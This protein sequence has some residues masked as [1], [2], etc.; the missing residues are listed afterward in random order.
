MSEEVL[1]LPELL[2]RISLALFHSAGADADCKQRV[3]REEGEEEVTIGSLVPRPFT[4]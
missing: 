4:S 1:A 2:S 3:H